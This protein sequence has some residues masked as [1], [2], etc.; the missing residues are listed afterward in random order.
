[1]SDNPVSG[2]KVEPKFKLRAVGKAYLHSVVAAAVTATMSIMMLDI[3]TPR[4][5]SDAFRRIYQND[6]F[7]ILLSIAA[8]LCGAFVVAALLGIVS[9]CATLAVSTYW[10]RHQSTVYVAGGILASLLL[11]PAA[12]YLNFEPYSV[13]QFM[14]WRRWLTLVEFPLLFVFPGA[15]GGYAFWRHARRQPPISVWA[16]DDSKA[17]NRK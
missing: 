12:V 4:Q 3:V 11:M 17:V 8:L 14:F 5:R 10:K 1:M 6:G 9:L 15:V 13:V 16:A 2:E 7:E